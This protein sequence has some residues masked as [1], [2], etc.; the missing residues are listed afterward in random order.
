MRVVLSESVRNLRE[1]VPEFALNNSE[2]DV[3]FDD[4]PFE[5]INNDEVMRIVYQI[6]GM[7]LEKVGPISSALEA[8]YD[9]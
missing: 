6:E 9:R 4:H 5:F 8:F 2:I 1:I 3:H 7:V